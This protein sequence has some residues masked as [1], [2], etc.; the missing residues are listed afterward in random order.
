LQ[1]VTAFLILILRFDDKSMM[2]LKVMK[3]TL[4]S[5]HYI[6]LISAKCVVPALKHFG[7]NCLRY[8]PSAHLDLF[9]LRIAKSNRITKTTAIG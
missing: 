6:E 2:F 5:V 8:G 3:Y 7:G 4:Q 9:A 1:P